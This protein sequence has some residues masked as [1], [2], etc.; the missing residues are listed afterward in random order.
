M[1]YVCYCNKVTEADICRAMAEGAESLADVI[2]ITGAMKSR[3]CHLN[4]PKGECCYPDLAA[5]YAKLKRSVGGQGQEPE[6][7]CI[8]CICEA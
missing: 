1:E 8:S 5:V 6:K 2:R 7:Q 3:N 4:N